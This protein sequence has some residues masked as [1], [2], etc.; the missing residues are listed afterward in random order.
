MAI[1]YTT[2]LGL[3]QP[4]PGTE[5]N[6][7]GTVVNDEL[8]ALV[9]SAIAGASTLNVTAGNV[10]LTDTAGVANQAR[11]AILIATGTPG[12]TRNIVAPSQSKTYI[13]INQAD[14]SV[15]L[16]GS[17]TTGVAV[18]AGQAATCVWNGS[19][20]E[21]AAS[22]D[23][24]GPSSATDNAIARYDGTTGKL[25]QNS[26]VTI[27]DSNNVSGVVQLNA[28]TVDTTNV[29]VTNLKAKDGTAAGS[30]ADSTGVVTLTTLASTTGNITTVN[31]TTVDTTNIEVTNLK[32]K[33]GTAAGSIADS[34]GVVTLAST[35]LTTTDINGGTIDGVTIG[36]ASAGAGTFTNL[37][38]TGTLTGGTGVVN[39]GSGQVYKDASGNVGIGTSSPASFGAGYSVLTVQNSTSGIIQA[40]NGTVTTEIATFGTIGL[41]GTR[42]NHALGF[43]TNGSE[44]VRIDTSGN[45]GIGT[46]SPAYKLDVQG[47]DIRNLREGAQGGLQLF[48]HSS[49][50]AFHAPRIQTWR[51]RGTASSPSVVSSGDELFSLQSSGYNASAGYTY[52]GGMFLYAT[53]TITG[54]NVP[55]YMTFETSSGSAATERMR[56]DSSGNLLVGKTSE[57]AAN[58]GFAATPAVG[59]R[60]TTTSTN[61]NI[62]NTASATGTETLIQFRYSDVAKG[63][64]ACNGTSIA[65]NT[66]S[67]YRLKENVAPMQN[68]LATV[69]ALKPV[70]YTWKADGSAGQGFIAHELQ[71]VVPDC[72][73]GEK[74]A[75]DKDGKPQYQGVDTS[76]L[77]ATLVSALQEQQALIQDLTTRLTTLEGN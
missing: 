14:A 75:V 52:T 2:L 43:I 56:I 53:G 18:R 68:A 7:W 66:T 42:S 38:Y 45:V 51:T 61:F 58:V 6:T 4:V 11:M 23:V 60:A 73:T 24:D 59:F 41:A 26:G 29:E 44:R 35:V 46:A 49:T 57:N 34:T 28:T 65:Y 64:I 32:A 72:V 63:G 16:K 74:D 33:D 30:I 10:T 76:F 12:T 48:T 3:A 17:A 62:C 31:A 15:V 13:V 54:G 22:G 36:G 69:A 71:A 5:A 55:S 39:I 40:S 47:G 70:T 67:D 1:N 50:Q 19:D 77:V 21:I 9:D 37:A 27:D 25:I 20:F 8:T